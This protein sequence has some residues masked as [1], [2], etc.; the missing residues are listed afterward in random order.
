MRYGCLNKFKGNPMKRF[1]GWGSLLAVLS[2]AFWLSWGSTGCSEVKTPP[3]AVP[4]VRGGE[5]DIEL[6]FQIADAHRYA[7]NIAFRCP[8]KNETECDRVRELAIGP[9]TASISKINGK[10]LSVHF[11]LSKKFP[12]GFK[13]ILERS[14]DSEGIKLS[15]WGSG[16]FDKELASFELDVGRYHL[17]ASAVKIDP[18]LKNVEIDLNLV[19]PYRGK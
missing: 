14:V 13:S 12:G 10:P 19:R 2:S 7:L 9:E 6:D 3:L 17:S 1:E 15:S 11:L 8:E 16:A 4:L 18:A 5:L